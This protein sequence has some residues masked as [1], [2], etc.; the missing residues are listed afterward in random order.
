MK[1]KKKSVEELVKKRDEI[2]GMELSAETGRMVKKSK[3]HSVDVWEDKDGQGIIVD[4]VRFPIEKEPF[5]LFLDMLAGNRLLTKQVE[6][7]KLIIN[8]YK[9]SGKPEGSGIVRLDKS[10]IIG[11]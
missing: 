2:L 7:L 3:G 8:K 10:G 9:I 5:E 11:I 1:G 4:D 6:E